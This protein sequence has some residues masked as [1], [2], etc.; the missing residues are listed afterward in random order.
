MCVK[1]L[2]EAKV[3]KKRRYIYIEVYLDGILANI[4]DYLAENMVS[5]LWIGLGPW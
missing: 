3:N 5:L 4:A 2:L 1:I